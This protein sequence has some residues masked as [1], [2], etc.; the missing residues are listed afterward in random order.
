M[1]GYSRGSGQP[2]TAEEP[3]Y[4]AAKILYTHSVLRGLTTAILLLD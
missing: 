4:L 2:V 1:V 3:L